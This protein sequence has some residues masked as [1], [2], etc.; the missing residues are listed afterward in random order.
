MFSC[1]KLYS[2]NFQLHFLGEHCLMCYKIRML[3]CYES[4]N[5]VLWNE[6]LI[7]HVFYWDY[8]PVS[9][10]YQ[11]ERTFN[12][13]KRNFFFDCRCL[14]RE[15]YYW[16]TIGFGNPWLYNAWPFV[17]NDDCFWVWEIVL[18][19]FWSKYLI[20]SGCGIIRKSVYI[21]YQ[22]I[23]SFGTIFRFSRTN[24]IVYYNRI[25]VRLRKIMSLMQWKSW[26]EGLV[27][28]LQILLKILDCPEIER[29]L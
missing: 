7:L 15:T 2:H 26:W 3:M 25:T 12:Y 21:Q 14:L 10:N 28:Y 9:E 22:C 19:C 23:C 13:L 1:I 18:R 4:K 11:N 20:V 29:S 6:I 5:Y 27:L 8:L 24:Q 17:L 16:R